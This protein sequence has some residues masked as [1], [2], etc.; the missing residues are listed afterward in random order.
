VTSGQDPQLRSAPAGDAVRYAAFLRGINL[1]GR[2]VTGEQLRA[3]FEALGFQGVA[4]FLA[5]GNVVFETDDADDLETRLETAL[6]GALGFEVEVFVRT[7]DEVAAIAGCQPFSAEMLAATDG[8]LQ[9]TFLRDQPA[10]TDV[11][12]AM[13]HATDQDRLTVIGR[14]WY[15][16]PAAGISTSTLDVKAV[17]RAL[18]RGT[19]RTHNTVT[20]LRA[21]LLP[22]PPG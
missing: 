1:G 4:S 17:E 9:V 20:R 8:K 3:P 15:W 7:A 13:A 10:P 19:T 11:E 12:V 21:K 14:E 6:H 2:R 5:S 16:L 22:H 18:G